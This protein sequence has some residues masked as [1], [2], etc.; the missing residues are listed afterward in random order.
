MNISR[1]IL[2]LDTFIFIYLFDKYFRTERV[3]IEKRGKL[4][5]VVRCPK[6]RQLIQNH[7]G[8][9]RQRTVE[10]R[11][12]NRTLP[13]SAALPLVTPSISDSPR[14]PHPDPDPRQLTAGIRRAPL[15]RPRLPPH[16]SVGRTI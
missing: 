11:K 5:N 4:S 15:A 3:L 10:Q 2:V 12:T 6:K 16:M 1:Y 7:T 14:S 8:R 13:G 9:D